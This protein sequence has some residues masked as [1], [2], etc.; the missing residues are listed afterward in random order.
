MR[1]NHQRRRHAFS[2][3]F[4][5]DRALLNAAL[6]S[7]P[8]ADVHTDT[9]SLHVK[10][11]GSNLYSSSHYTNGRLVM[12]YDINAN[13]HVAKLG[14]VNLQGSYSITFSDE[15]PGKHPG[16]V[17]SISQ[18]TGTLSDSHGDQVFLS[19]GGSDLIRNK[20]GTFSLSGAVTGGSGSYA[21]ATGSMHA[22]GT[23][24]SL[25]AI[26]LSLTLNF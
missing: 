1:G 5:E 7:A 24:K 13:G 15:I 21:G 11:A 3:D 16:F 8:T 18:G 10:L 12:I 2:I 14:H 9:S 17:Y 25:E 4:L 20:K 26:Q 19:Y 22:N 6:P 23:A